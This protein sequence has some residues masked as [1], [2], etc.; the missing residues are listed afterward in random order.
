VCDVDHG[1]LA[2]SMCFPVSAW[3]GARSWRISIGDKAP[4]RS[5]MFYVDTDNNNHE[6]KNNRDFI[7][8]LARD[9]DFL[10]RS[11]PEEAIFLVGYVLSELF[12]SVRTSQSWQ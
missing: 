9:T 8:A 4:A 1:T 10:A 12:G 6:R 7:V 5:R 3:S 2:V 11:K